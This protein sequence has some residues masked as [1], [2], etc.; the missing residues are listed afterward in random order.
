MCS[1]APV[2]INASTNPVQ[3]WATL[4]TIIEPTRSETLQA[5]QN[6]IKATDKSTLTASQRKDLR[7]ESRSI[8]RE[9]KQISGGVYLSTGAIILIVVLLIILL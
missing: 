4:T 2:Q 3:N 5:R 1:F 7:K 9:L 8:K 6:E